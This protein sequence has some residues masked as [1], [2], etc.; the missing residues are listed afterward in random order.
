MLRAGAVE[1]ETRGQGDAV[2]FIHGAI[3]GDAFAPLMTEPALADY[4]LIRYRRRGYGN[5]DPPAGD[6][7]IEEQAD[8]ARSLLTS[9]G[10]AR[11]HVVGYSGGGPIAIQLALDE[12]ELVQSLVL[13]EPALQNA[14]W[15]A[16]FHE[17]IT[18]LIEMHRAGDSAQA[19]HRWM[20]SGGN[21]EWRRDIEEHIPGA[22]D[23]AIADAAGTFEY[24]LEAIRHWDFEAIGASRVT[25]PVLDVVGSRN[26]TSRRPISDMLRAVIPHTEVV[27]IP[28]A[29]HSLQ[30]TQPAVLAAVISDFLS[31][32]TP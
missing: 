10:V 15:A 14:E 20:S 4:Q 2:L 18:P 27:T 24:D 28:D 11:A 3:I 19:V 17:L 22:G 29:D 13:L 1:Y 7:T 8:D 16:A 6:P 25:Q 21:A 31:R 32:A 30:M 5:S 9:L 26:A 12:P 23:Q